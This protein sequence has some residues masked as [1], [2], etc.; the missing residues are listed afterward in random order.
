MDILPSGSIFNELQAIH[1]TGYLPSQPSL[2]ETWQQR[3]VGHS[4]VNMPSPRPSPRARLVNSSR[5]TSRP[6]PVGTTT[7]A[8]EAK[9]TVTKT[10]NGGNLSP[11]QPSSPQALLRVDL[12]RFNVARKHTRARRHSDAR[13]QRH[14]RPPGEYIRAG[15]D[16]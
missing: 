15:H 16:E 4:H 8:D 6:S 11:K 14:A 1:D 3:R 5:Q 9:S 13:S 2:E 10:E 7:M 12:T